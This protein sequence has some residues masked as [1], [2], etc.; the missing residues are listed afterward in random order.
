MI[1]KVYKIEG[2]SCNHCVMAVKKEIS[3]LNLAKM[4]VEIGTAKVNFD[5][6]KVDSSA[7]EKAILNA[8]FKVPK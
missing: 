1:E 5:D 4:E 3:K 7:I 6:T 8:G 2:M